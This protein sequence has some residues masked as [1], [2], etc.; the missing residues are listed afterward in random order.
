M[1]TSNKR[2]GELSILKKRM[3]SAQAKKAVAVFATP[4]SLVSFLHQ[5][6]CKILA[7]L[8]KS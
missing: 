8:E 6:A 1:T 7:G 3:N 4:F 2:L 5:G